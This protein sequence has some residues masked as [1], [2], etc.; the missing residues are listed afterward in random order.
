ME[1]ERKFLVAV[2]P[3]HGE[4][5]P[6]RIR[7]G[8]VAVAADAGEVRVRDRDGACTLTVKQGT[9]LVRDEHDITITPE[10][11]DSLWPATAGRRVEKQRHLVPYEGVTIELD[12][13]EGDLAGLRIAEVEFP[14]VAAA[15]AFVPP[16][17]FGPEVTG[18]PRYLNQRL[19]L[20]GV[21]K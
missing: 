19:A 10:L 14:T 3:P 11:F 20:H 7:Q 17:W 18:D 13:F 1:I 12:V 9:G 2:D 8:Y 21:P 6:L 5:P 15:E 4:R 16:G